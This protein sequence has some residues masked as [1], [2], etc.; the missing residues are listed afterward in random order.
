MNEVKLTQDLIRFKNLYTRDEGITKFLQKK[1][2]SI[3]FKC[4]IIKSKGFNSSKP[5]LNLY[6]KYGK[7]KPHLMTVSHSDVVA[8]IQGWKY[9]PFA[10]KIKNGYLYGRGAQDLSLIHI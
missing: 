2:T 7:S 9:P 3:G 4:T 6:A 5:A 10:A 1:L 8:N